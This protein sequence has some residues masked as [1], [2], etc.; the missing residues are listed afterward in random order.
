MSLERFLLAECVPAYL[1]LDEERREF[2]GL[3]ATEKYQEVSQMNTTWYEKGF[4]A[5]FEK[6]QA[7]NATML[8]KG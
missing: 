8:E 6:A 5:G 2:E 1:P 7:Q 3:M 4:E